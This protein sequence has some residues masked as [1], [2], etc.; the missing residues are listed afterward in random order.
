MTQSKEIANWDKEYPLRLRKKLGDEAPP[1]LYTVGDV[2]LLNKRSVAVTGSRKMSEL[3]ERFSFDIGEIIANEKRVLVSG[4]AY[5]CDRNATET[6]IKNGGKAV[7]F[8]AVPIMEMLR[9]RQVSNW[10]SNGD[11]VICS[12]FDPFGKFDGKIA[13]R[14]NHYIYANAETA[15]VCQCNSKI[16]GTYSGASYALRNNLCEL[17]VFDNN[18]EGERLLIKNGAISVIDA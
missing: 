6:A 5:G 10:I 3:G 4:G 17:F 11:L 16:S 7:W 18:S 1:V 2:A 9:D 8:V 15:F 14:R 13:L 12:D